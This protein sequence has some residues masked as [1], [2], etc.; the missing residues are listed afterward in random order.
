MA[1][2]GYMA[3]EMMHSLF[4]IGW[5]TGTTLVYALREAIW[6]IKMDSEKSG[7]RSYKN[8]LKEDKGRKFTDEIDFLRVAEKQKSE[9]VKASVTKDDVI[10]LQKMCQRYGVDYHLR[11]RPQNLESLV[12]KKYVNN[13]ILTSREDN[14]LKSF[15][16]T[17]PTGKPMMDPANPKIPLLKKDDYLLTFKTKDIHKWEIICER[18]EE[19][20]MSIKQSIEKAKQ[21]KEHLLMKKVEKQLEKDPTLNLVPIIKEKGNTQ[22]K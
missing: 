10:F 4:T 11:T 1:D 7:E 13:E 5:S 18:L 2:S 16:L 6:Q 20:N 12:Q 22:E 15:I 14:I 9:M 3:K 8:Y 19:K 21:T 17:D